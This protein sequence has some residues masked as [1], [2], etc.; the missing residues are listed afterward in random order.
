MNSSVT[1]GLAYIFNKYLSG[2]IQELNTEQVLVSVL[3]GDI[4]LADLKLT[5]MEFPE[6]KLKL[7]RGHINSF[8]LKIPWNQVLMADSCV[9]PLEISNISLEFTKL[10]NTS[11]PAEDPEELKEKILKAFEEKI[12]NKRSSFNKLREVLSNRLFNIENIEFI[13]SRLEIQISNIQISI[14]PY[15]EKN[16]N[17]EKNLNLE[18]SIGSLSIVPTDNNFSPFPNKSSTLWEKFQGFKSI[19]IQK[20]N[21]TLSDSY[22]QF[23]IIT[24]KDIN[25]N[26][27]NQVKEN[28]MTVENIEIFYSSKNYLWIGQSE[29][30]TDI[31]IKANVGDIQLQLNHRNIDDINK[32]LDPKVH[33]TSR[34]RKE[35]WMRARDLVIKRVRMKS[36]LFITRKI[37]WRSIYKKLYAKFVLKIEPK[38]P[39]PSKELDALTGSIK[40]EGITKYFKYFMPQIE[41]NVKVEKE[42]PKSAIIPAFHFNVTC[43]V[44]ELELA[45]M[46]DLEKNLE[47][48]EIIKYRQEEQNKYDYELFEKSARANSMLNSG[49]GKINNYF[50]SKGKILISRSDDSK[51]V[52]LLVKAHLEKIE[53]RLKAMND[54]YLN[55]IFYGISLNEEC[56][57][58]EPRFRYKVTNYDRKSLTIIKV[59]SIRVYDLVL[60]DSKIVKKILDLQSGAQFDIIH[61][62]K[63]VYDAGFT[64]S[65]TQKVLINIPELYTFIV[66]SL[67]SGFIKCFSKIFK[68]TQTNH[69]R[70]D[71][72]IDLLEPMQD[73]KI[74]YKHESPLVF[75]LN[76]INSEIII[77]KS[78][79]MTDPVIKLLIGG[80]VVKSSSIKQQVDIKC[81]EAFSACFNQFN[82]IPGLFI[83]SIFKTQGIKLHV[84]ENK[85]EINL[86]V[87]QGDLS[88]Q[89]FL[90]IFQISQSWV[91]IME[92]EA[93]TPQVFTISLKSKWVEH[94]LQRVLSSF[95]VNISTICINIHADTQ[96][97]RVIV[98]NLVYSNAVFFLESNS[99]ISAREINVIN[100]NTGQILFHMFSAKEPDT[101]L[102]LPGKIFLYRDSLAAFQFITQTIDK[103]NAKYKNI[104]ST[105]EV[106]FSNFHMGLDLNLIDWLFNLQKSLSHFSSPAEHEYNSVIISKT[107]F[108]GTNFSIN[109][110]NDRKS[111]YFLLS[112]G[113]LLII[114]NYANKS[115]TRLRL[116]SPS[117]IDT[118]IESSNHCFIF[119]P[120]SYDSVIDVNYLSRSKK[121]GKIIET[122]NEVR[123]TEIKFTYLNR[124]VMEA[125][126]YFY[127]KLMSVFSSPPQEEVKN[128]ST[129]SMIFENSEIWMPRNSAVNEGFSIKFNLF[130][131]TNVPDYSFLKTRKFRYE[132][133]EEK[134]N[135][136]GINVPKFSE[137]QDGYRKTSK[138]FSINGYKNAEKQEVNYVHPEVLRYEEGRYLYGV[139]VLFYD[140]DEETHDIKKRVLRKSEIKNENSESDPEKYENFNFSKK[141]FFHRTHSSVKSSSSSEKY[142][143]HLNARDNY[144]DL[145]Q[146]RNSLS[147]DSSEIEEER[148]QLDFDYKVTFSGC[149]LVDIY[150]NNITKSEF[151]LTFKINFSCDPMNITIDSEEPEFNLRLYQSQYNILLKTFQENF[152]EL[153]KSEPSIPSPFNKIWLEAQINL[154]NLSLYLISSKLEESYD[155]YLLPN[156]SSLCEIKF[157]AFTVNV[158]MW[159]SGKKEIKIN[160]KNFKI[161]DMRIGSDYSLEHKYPAAYMYSA[162]IDIGSHNYSDRSSGE[163]ESISKLIR[164]QSVAPLIQMEK[165][166]KF[167]VIVD[168]EGKKDICVN[169]NYAIFI[170]LPDFY[171]DIMAFFQCPYDT[172]LFRD[173]ENVVFYDD[174][175]PPGMKLVVNMEKIHVLL[176][177]SLKNIDSTCFLLR[178]EMLLIE[179]NWN[180]NCYEGPGTMNVKLT[181]KL[182]GG[183]LV[184]AKYGQ[185]FSDFKFFDSL[186]EKY[187]L[188]ITYMFHKP[189]KEA[190]WVTSQINIRSE[191][192]L[193]LKVNLNFSSIPILKLILNNFSNSS[194]RSDRFKRVESPE[195]QERLP[196][197]AEQSKNQISLNLA[198][199]G[200]YCKLLNDQMQPIFQANIKEILSAYQQE[201]SV[202][203]CEANFI[204]VLQ[205]DYF[206]QKLMAWEPMIEE[207]GLEIQYS[208]A[209]GFSLIEISEYNNI[210]H[211]NISAALIS[212]LSSIW[213]L[214]SNLSQSSQN[215]DPSTEPYV[216]YNLTGI[217]IKLYIN[218]KGWS[219][220]IDIE[221]LPDDKKSITLDELNRMNID[222]NPSHLTYEKRTLNIDINTDSLDGGR[223]P[224][225]TRFRKVTN[226]GIDTPDTYFIYLESYGERNNNERKKEDKDKERK[227]KPLLGRVT[228][229]FMDVEDFEEFEE[230]NRIDEDGCL[231][232]LRKNPNTL[233]EFLRPRQLKLMK[234]TIIPKS[235]SW[236]ISN[237]TRSQVRE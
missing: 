113:V 204:M 75:N 13:L 37:L 55:L 156:S 226:I 158:L 7:S 213:P 148:P 110:L 142:S 107:I 49:L 43:P 72:L 236:S 16:E 212:T 17:T 59:A 194:V 218:Q 26:M 111:N 68:S 175:D 18:F 182:E 145:S 20:S 155:E 77:G 40:N 63:H 58:T 100:T 188:K 22:I 61:N 227:K 31:L 48:S 179:V 208:C 137:F 196:P 183:H 105:S 209:E 130:E 93:S 95:I 189:P 94:I 200:F 184:P 97:L 116:K 161:E 91:N 163:N 216:F 19:A 143:N 214:L 39:S 168:I 146:S 234:K 122:I 25:L 138:Y 187:E 157:E 104:I 217:P 12:K 70:E 57:F 180:G 132:E 117:L 74:F 139:D 173:P 1:W 69:V 199:Y 140:P 190:D 92:K 151:T 191:K 51:V 87:I 167:E 203:N 9:I 147:S 197:P 154:R 62:L 192:S 78:Y 79:K 223:M 131:V 85:T 231:M 71:Y 42:K 23:K 27:T 109:F 73:F 233:K 45:L 174:E 162:S 177:S 114:D 112:P 4:K 35:N 228:K 134:K 202:Q 15:D 166:T 205:V 195:P 8:R 185:V 47:T 235:L 56:L 129:F 176:L 141:S 5:S 41:Y 207:W 133:H 29:K 44:E 160:A 121:E 232:F 2:K 224:S 86:K 24:F 229:K 206:N 38:T 127:Y 32:I 76:I 34:T 119:T 219:K 33:R 82:N 159:E 96:T 210:L 220:S 178:F 14:K 115:E 144:Q 83:Y 149:H 80:V 53:V 123:F 125:Y 50:K 3:K 237:G 81:I 152:F 11:E 21:V 99:C 211:L 198:L 10:L 193:S 215:N 181:I 135:K 30:D 90:N 172:S 201:S 36:W 103:L 136:L 164:I 221:Q 66:P 230:Q 84:F 186:I 98:K 108:H 171:S 225:H 101:V 120:N 88:N 170:V 89:E 65:I 118:S 165:E 67:Y 169:F 28:L 126:N 46:A 60:N 102:V 54:F 6:L 124:V 52:N 128:F 106:T 150:Q 222:T 153:Y 64:E